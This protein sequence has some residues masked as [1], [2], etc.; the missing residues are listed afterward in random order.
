MQLHVYKGGSAGVERESR[1]AVAQTCRLRPTPSPYRLGVL[2]VPR[3]HGAQVQASGEVAC[4]CAG[5]ARWGAFVRGRL[6]GGP[7]WPQYEVLTAEFVA[8]L[9][10]YLRQAVA[11]K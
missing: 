9:A 6:P 1:R 11:P 8:G 2:T 10:A 4:S 3:S 5:C 7:A